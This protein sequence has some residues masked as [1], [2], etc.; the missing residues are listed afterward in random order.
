MSM[1]QTA[2]DAARAAGRILMENYGRVRQSHIDNKQQ[3]DFVTHVDRAAETEIVRL[4]R[5]RYPDHKFYAEE[6]VKDKSGGHRWIIDPLD[7]TTNYIHAVPVFAVSIGLEVDGEIV[8]GVIYDPTRDELFVA[9]KNNGAVL[10]GKPIAVSEILQPDRALLGT[11]FPFRS[12]EHL[13]LY[14]E[15]FSRLFRETSGIRRLGAVALDFCNIACGRFDG[16][17]EIGLAP[18]DV[19][20]GYLLIREAGGKICDFGG[21]DQPV[22][23]GNVVA[24]NPHIYPIVLQAV[25]DSFGERIPR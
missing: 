13:E 18:W 11:G 14:Q 6:G 23:T 16:F 21:G 24:G 9:E 7:G 12:R 15:S 19:A 2:V 5:E 25:Q 10:N 3:F 8:V 4:I 1:R 17:W 22:W 20:A